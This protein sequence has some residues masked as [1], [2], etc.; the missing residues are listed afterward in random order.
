MTGEVAAI[1]ERDLA[2]ILQHTVVQNLRDAAD[3]EMSEILEDR[4]GAEIE[5][6]TNRQRAPAQ[7][8]EFRPQV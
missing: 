4:I 2:G 6:R 5:R 3:A 7:N 1:L 8:V